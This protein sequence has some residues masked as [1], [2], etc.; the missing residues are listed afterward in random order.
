[1]GTTQGFQQAEQ[2]RLMAR[3]EFDVFDRNADPALDEI[4]ELAAV[5]SL[6]DFSYIGWMDFN[7]LWFRAKFGFSAPEQARAA[8]ACNWVL[9]TGQ[10]LL[11][12]DASNT[13]L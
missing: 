9:T 10:P 4:T 1:M 5:L 2:A 6:A 13:P 11:V 12:A 3:S 8:T 7:R